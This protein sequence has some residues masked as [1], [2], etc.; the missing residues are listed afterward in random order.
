MEDRFGALWAAYQHYGDPTFVLRTADLYAAAVANDSKATRK[1][2]SKRAS[3]TKK[4]QVLKATRGQS[5]AARGR[6]TSTSVSKKTKT[7]GTK[8]ARKRR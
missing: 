3:T 1:R 5:T 6:V 4:A 2:A 7:V 8:R